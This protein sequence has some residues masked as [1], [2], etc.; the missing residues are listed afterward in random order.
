[1]TKQEKIT[2]AKKSVAAAIGHNVDIFEQDKNLFIQSGDGDSF[3]TL[4]NFGSTA[5][6]IADKAILDW[7]INKFAYVPGNEITKGENLSLLQSKLREYNKEIL[8]DYLDISFMRLDKHTGN[9]AA[10][11]H[12]DYEFEIYEKDRLAELDKFYEEQIFSQA[13]DEGRKELLA[14]VARKDGEIVA[15]ASCSAGYKEAF[16]CINVDTL[17]NYRGAGLATHLVAKIAAEIESRG[18]IP[19]YTTWETN[20]ASMHVASATGFEPVWLWCWVFDTE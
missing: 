9:P 20:A 19:L 16:W 11:E 3:F 18:H 12:N 13:L 17:I 5:V 2:Y 6:I 10:K 4:I 1:M 15:V 7:C 8:D 14:I